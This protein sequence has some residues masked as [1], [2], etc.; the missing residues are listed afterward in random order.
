MFNELFTRI[1]AGAILAGG[2]SLS[3]GTWAQNDEDGSE[4]ALVEVTVT[5]VT[6]DQ[7]FTPILVASHQAGVRLFELGE[8]ASPELQIVAEEGNVAPL[9][10][11]LLALPSVLDVTDSGALLDP[12]A[13]ATITVRVRGTFNHIS[14]AAM[15]IPTN[16]GFFALNGARMP[17]GR[18]QALVLTSVAYDAGSERNDEL[19][20][21]IPGPS[22]VECGGP[23]GGGQPAGGEEG[24]VHVHAG[25]HGIGDLDE[26]QRDWRNPV[27]RVTLK[28]VQ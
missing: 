17:S 1:T 28:R 3:T 23:G 6:R 2:L 11:A 25:I 27:A 5:N 21:S 24:Y 26:A 19:C 22:F 15:L 4:S 12:G 8:P 16:D 10:A 20:A 13:S 14:L 18:N 7:Q 9:T